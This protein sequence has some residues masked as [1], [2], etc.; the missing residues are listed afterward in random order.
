MWIKDIR[1]IS[2]YTHGGF[3]NVY[4]DKCL[5]IPSDSLEEHS[6]DKRNIK[7]YILE[8]SNNREIYIWSADGVLFIILILIIIAYKFEDHR[9]KIKEHIKKFIKKVVPVCDEVKN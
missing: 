4:D 9:N 8:S 7:S 1:N 6:L 2:G 5:K 3:D